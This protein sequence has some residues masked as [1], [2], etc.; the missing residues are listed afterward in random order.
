MNKQ[1]KIAVADDHELFR[2]GMVAIL[3]S[4]QEMK[5]CF[6]AENGQELLDL[7]LKNGE[8]DIVLLDL[9]MPVMDGF[10]TI[11]Q[12]KNLHPN[13][14]VILLSMHSDDRYILH[15]MESG[16]NS[17][18]HKNTHPEEVETAIK[19][20]IETGFYFNDKVSKILLKGVQNKDEERY[21]LPDKEVLSE[22]EIEVLK[23]LCE[24]NTTTEISEKL[25]LSPR[26]IEGYRKQLIQ[27]TGVKNIAGLVIYSI[28]TGIVSLNK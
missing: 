1:I 3:N 24:E 22:R 25:H 6:E 11:E 16:A 10:K 12:L 18:L 4:N 14:K 9:E 27:K 19:K 7:I 2:R 26:T 8:P 15:F 5:V 17:Y 21:N 23:L 28:K 13:V 20:V